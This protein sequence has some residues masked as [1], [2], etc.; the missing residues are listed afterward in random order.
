MAF[1]STSHWPAR[2]LEPTPLTSHD[3]MLC[4]KIQNTMGHA[5]LSQT[6]SLLFE[7]LPTWPFLKHGMGYSV[8]I[9]NYWTEAFANFSVTWESQGEF[10]VANSSYGL[11]TKVYKYSPQKKILQGKAVK[12]S[13]T[14]LLVAETRMGNAK[15]IAGPPHATRGFYLV[16]LK[17]GRKVMK[18]RK[19]TLHFAT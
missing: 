19:Q 5:C 13:V 1:Y 12:S 8:F 7:C 3:S 15:G 14:S 11:Q 17:P 4:I 6:N 18:V 9:S 2:L 10:H 16:Q